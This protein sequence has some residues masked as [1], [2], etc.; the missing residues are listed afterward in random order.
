MGLTDQLHQEYISA[1]KA[2]NERV[3]SVIRMFKTAIKN[4]EIESGHPLSEEELVVVAR[5]LIKQ[6]T[7]ARADFERGGRADLVAQA[8]AEITQLRTYVPASMGEDELAPLVD[9]AISATGAQ[10]AGEIG[11][12][13]GIVMKQAG[14]R[15]DGTLVRTIALKRLQK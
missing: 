5:R 3:V 13:M 8:D 12:V 2:K 1:L 14:A 6:S 4:Q 15:A 11:K 10:G 9:A 7:D